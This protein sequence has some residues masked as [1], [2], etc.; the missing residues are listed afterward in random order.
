[1]DHIGIDAWIDDPYRFR[2]SRDVGAYVGLRPRVRNSGG[3]E[4]HGKIT[5]AGDVE[6]RR[7]LVQAAQMLLNAREDCAL[8]RW[9][10]ALATRCGRNKAAV[11]V[12]RKLAIVLHRMWV[13]E[14][15]FQA[16]PQ[17]A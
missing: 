16:F 2:R 11:A 7:L 9:G 8:K 14:E 1:M 4:R 5:R 10:L 17:A 12:A 15:S 6:M 3:R 13:R